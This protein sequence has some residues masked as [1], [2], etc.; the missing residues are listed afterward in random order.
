MKKLVKSQIKI[1]GT[2][3]FKGANENALKKI[4]SFFL[5]PFIF[6]YERIFE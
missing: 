6:S 2:N 4:V 5:I 3:T 1:Q